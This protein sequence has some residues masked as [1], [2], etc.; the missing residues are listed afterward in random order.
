MRSEPTSPH[1]SYRKE[2]DGLRAFAVLAVVLYHFAVPGFKAGFIGV[3]VFFVIS[4]FLIGG[5][6]WSEM[7][8][9][10]RIDLGQFY[11]RRIRRLAP[12]FFAMATV[13]TLVGFFVLLPFE[14]RNFGK[15]LIASSLW[16]SN[17]LFYREAGYF[18]FGAENRVLLHTWSLSVEEQFYIVLPL[19]LT[20]LLLA[21]TGPRV[22]LTCLIAIWAASLLACVALTAGYPVMT[23]YLFPYRA[24]EMLSGVLLAIWLR[25]ASPAPWLQATLASA[26]F[27]LLGASLLLIKSAGFPGWQALFPV[28]GSAALLAG[29]TNARG[30]PGI[31]LSHPVLTFFGLISYSLYLWHWP[32]LILSRYWRGAY[33]SP[34]ET[35]GWLVLAVVTAVLSWRFIE[36]PFRRSLRVTRPVLLSSTA[37]AACTVL[38]LG[39]AAFVTNGLP[40]RFSSGTQ[41]YIT[42]SGGFLQD[43]SRCHRAAG[44]PLAGIETCSIGPDGPAEFLIWGDSHLRAQMDGLAIA[45]RDVGRPGLIVWHAGCPPLFGLVKRENAATPDQDRACSE[46]NRRIRS[47]LRHYPG[48]RRLLLVGRWAYYA[49][50]RGVGR[51]ARN[52]ITLAPERGSGLPHNVGQAELFGIALK[53]TVAELSRTG[54]DVYLLRQVPELPQ[55]DSIVLARDMAYGRLTA[56]QASALASVEM[57]VLLNRNRLAEV[58][59]DDLVTHRQVN[60]IDPWPRLCRERCS[61]IQNGVS[62]YFDNNHMSYAG[63]V[64]LRDLFIPFLSGNTAIAV[65]GP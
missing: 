47:A 20:L 64:Q 11:L 6:L 21:R 60:L 31:V 18:D 48:I 59:I 16:M 27:L 49:D 30:N 13:S 33:A 7:L 45:A 51:D 17:I 38:S 15:E 40:D 61:G 24:W 12:A 36:Q 35:A 55:Y 8:D 29:A 28:A 56:L 10:G 50:G 52:V 5:M 26:G 42:A 4:G 23:F 54:H 62:L 14:F 41:V 3:D 19:L 53:R 63:A 37:F 46:D 57:P 9:T 39:T 22:I 43:M 1:G 58:P 25:H 2:I 44:G 65:A 32:L 34:M